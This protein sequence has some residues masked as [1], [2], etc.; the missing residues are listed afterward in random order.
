MHRYR[1]AVLL[2]A[3]AACG[4]AAC[5]GQPRGPGGRALEDPAA[6]A[7]LTDSS[8]ARAGVATFSDSAGTARLAVSVTGLKPGLHGIHIHET[9]TCT[10]PD[11]ESAGS[12]FNPG[13]KKHGLENPEGPH[14]GDLPNLMVEEDG[15][16]DTTLTVPA[17]L[18]V[19][20][21]T[22][23]LGTQQR[24]LVIHADPDDQK[25]DPSGNSGARVVC[26]VIER[27]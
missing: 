24:A 3:G 22:S 9:G 14:A 18:L 5:G 19:E 21:P 26:G 10:P 4:L 11:F 7:S 15:S 1:L 6:T 12:H 2:A 20:G 17:G 27:G 8:G 13:A 23:M 25:T 16:A